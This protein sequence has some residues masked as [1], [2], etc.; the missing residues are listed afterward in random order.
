MQSPTNLSSGPQEQLLGNVRLR[1]RKDAS[2]CRII[3]DAEYHADLG[4]RSLI[5]A[6]K[7]IVEDVLVESYLDV[8]REIEENNDPIEFM[9][10]VQGG[11]VVINM[12]R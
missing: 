2:V 10:D 1:V 3:A 9:V 5:T 4:A 7:G 6:V 8:E 11:E 12:V